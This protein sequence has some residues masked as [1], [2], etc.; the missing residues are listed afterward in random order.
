MTSSI[1]TKRSSSLL[2]VAALLS[3]PSGAFAIAPHAEIGIGLPELVHVRTGAYL[4]P[5]LSV[6]AYAGN[7]ILNWLVGLGATVYVGGTPNGEAPPRHAGLV[8]VTAAFNPL[9]QPIRLTSGGDTLG[10]ALLVNTGY[11]YTA[12]SGF[13]FR[14]YVGGLLYED[15]GFAGGPNLS[16]GAGWRF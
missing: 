2:A 10:A 7:V 16:L 9:L 5:R 6:E 8:Q 12:D 1:H 14:A 3:I 4:T 13:S 11:A 15:G